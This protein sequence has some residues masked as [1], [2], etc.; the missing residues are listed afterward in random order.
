MLSGNEEH[1]G[2]RISNE[3]ISNISDTCSC[4]G[5]VLVGFRSS[6]AAIGLLYRSS[7][8]GF[9]LV[10][11]VGQNEADLAPLQGLSAQAFWP[12][13]GFCLRPVWSR[14]FS[15]APAQSFNALWPDVIRLCPPRMGSPFAL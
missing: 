6:S 1:A 4:S 8:S 9:V 7:R 15:L 3:L 13:T 12:T 2:V 11:V 14:H 10:P 5:W